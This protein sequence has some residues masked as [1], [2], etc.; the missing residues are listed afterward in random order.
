M[1]LFNKILKVLRPSTELASS[2]KDLSSRILA[3]R[4]PRIPMSSLHNTEF[5]LI[6]DNMQ[7]V[8]LPI[9]NLSLTGLGFSRSS[10]DTWPAIGAPLKGSLQIGVDSFAV[11][12]HVVHTSATTVG[13]HFENPSAA[14]TLAILKYFESELLAHQLVRISSKLL[15]ATDKGQPSFLFGKNNSEL[16]YIEN[17]NQLI[18]FHISFLGNYVEWSQAE[19]VRFGSIYDDTTS[20]KMRDRGTGFIRAVDNPSDQLIASIQRF[21][22][23]IEEAPPEIRE[24][25]RKAMEDRR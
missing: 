14:A 6:R 1:N 22:H 3:D 12:A 18:E 23:G 19:G 9:S 7:Q 2:R 21:I 4:A 17:D 10:L 15:A 11:T 24:Q 25:I 13:V 16:Y 8:Q 20:H 5:S